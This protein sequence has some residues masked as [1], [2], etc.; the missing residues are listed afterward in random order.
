MKVFAAVI[1]MLIFPGMLLAAP[2]TKYPA[3]RATLGKYREA[4]LVEMSVEKIM[5]SEL[6]AKETKHEGKIYFGR[7]QFRWENSTPTKTLLVFDGR[8]LWN[9]QYPDPDFP[10][11]LQVTKSKIDVKNRSQLILLDL[12][13]NAAFL[14][15]FDVQLSF[16]AN[17]KNK[18]IF[19]ANPKGKSLSIKDLKLHL[20]VS[21]KVLTAVSYKDDVENETIL[22]F[23][24]VKF[25]SEPEQKRFR[26][27]PP[28]DAKVTEL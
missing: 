13:S 23:S 25:K 9:V 5:K 16:D 18:A 6:M 26:Y 19:S 4:Q 8:L 21:E 24:D 27:S 1:S 12:L 11:P 17:D 20:L 10:G 22:N 7:G 2:A 28:K 14:E 15:N 3:L